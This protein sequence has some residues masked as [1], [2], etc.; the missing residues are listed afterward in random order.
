M[1]LANGKY[2]RTWLL[3]D[4]GAVKCHLVEIH[5]QRLTERDDL[6]N[7]RG[8]PIFESTDFLGHR[9]LFSRSEDAQNVN[10][11]GVN[12]IGSTF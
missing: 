6:F 3:V 11:G 1:R 4:K 7:L 8:D 5:R 9:V 2:R 12:L 10:I